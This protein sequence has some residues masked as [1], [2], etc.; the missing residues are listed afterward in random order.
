MSDIKSYIDNQL[1]DIT[2]SNELSNNI[3]NQTTYKKGK[4]HHRLAIRKAVVFTA[5]VCLIFTCSL[6]AFAATIPAFNDWIYTV[7]PKLAELLYPINKSAEDNGIK[8]TVLG[9]VN[10]NHNAAVYFTVQDTTDQNRVN[11]KLD[12]GDT[13]YIEGPYAFNIEMLSYDEKTNTALFAMRGSGGEGLSNRMTTFKISMLMSNKTTHDWYDTGIDIA[14][15]VNSNANS[16]PVSNFYYTGGSELPA[17]GLSVLE[18]DVMN[19]LLGDGIDF[20]TISNIGF[21]DGKLHIQTKWKTSFDNHGSLGLADENDV[22]NG[23]ANA[24]SYNN[25]YFRTAED[26]ANC[27]NNRF[28]K[29]IEYVFDV[30]RIEELSGCNLRAYLVEDGTFTE[31]KWKVNFRLS[32]S[33]HILIS[34]ADG[35]ADSVEV[36]SVGAYINGY[37]G[38]H[39]NCNLAIMMKNGTKLSYSYYSTKNSADAD[40][41]KRNV[42]IMFRTKLSSSYYSTGNLADAD[43]NKRNI[44]IMFNMPI[45]TKDISNISINGAVIYESR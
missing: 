19:I 7:T 44:S 34:K 29:H 10:D 16:L 18:P 8:V 12:L 14:S 39:E 22:A 9:A 36:T 1:A 32:D 21:V 45:D 43:S 40:S 13:C 11:E 20:V 35:I 27:G 2:V 31:G 37:K 26:S 6:S 41:N 28:A 33:D 25:Y 5:A 24:I 3:L 23:E 15:L 42:S 17:G 4:I 30:S 38:N